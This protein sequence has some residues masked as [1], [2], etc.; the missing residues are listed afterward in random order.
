VAANTCKIT[1]Y[2][3]WFD[4]DYAGKVNLQ[5][6]PQQIA[7]LDSTF[8][9]NSLSVGLHSYHT[10]F[11][12]DGGQW[13]SVVTEVFHKLPIVAAN[14]RKITEYEYWFDNDYAAKVTTNVAPQ[15]IFTMNNGI[16]ASALPVGLHYFHTRFRDDGKQWSSVVSE[17]FHKLNVS[18]S[19]P[20]LIT[21]YR[22]WYDMDNSNMFSVSLP[23]PVNPYQLIRSI[24]TCNL[25][26]GDHRIHFQFKDLRQAWSSVI[27]D[28][29]NIPVPVIPVITP[30]GATTIC[31]GSTITL[32]ASTANSYLWNTEATSQSIIV[33]DSGSYS[34]S[35]QNEC[36]VQLTSE[37]IHVALHPV[38][39]P[40]VSGP[41]ASVLGETVVYSTEASMSNYNWE[42]SAGGMIIAGAGTN[43][44]TVNWIDG[45][46]QQVGVSYANDNGCSPVSPTILVVD[47]AVNRTLNLN[48]LLQGLYDGDGMM[49]KSQ[50]SNGDKYPGTIA[51]KVIIELHSAAADEY[52]TIVYSTGLVDLNNIGA[53]SVDIPAMHNGM[54]YV[55]VKHRN[56]IETVS[57]VPI[58][59]NGSVISYVF[60]TPSKAFG[61]NLLL[62][63]DGYP[64]IYAGDVNHDGMV[65]AED[66]NQIY[67]GSI[68]FSSGYLDTDINGDGI[69]DALD[70]IMTDNNASK[71]ISVMKP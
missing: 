7:I 8:N 20:N 45:G 32:T 33:S 66:I 71:F 50:D 55:T 58:Q 44:I 10:R 64:V 47:V 23:T 1:E 17:V 49:H 12:D 46:N 65:D 4:N 42:V 3:Y 9:T 11:R 34:V 5:T 18:P 37:A 43:S 56:S 19:I 29:F 15:Q 27:T 35:I 2:E 13:S 16:D 28:T 62:T 69:I 52:P 21:D 26:S 51:D 53:I 67:S 24:N 57:A 31:A 63:E 14:T 70:L 68:L 6:A 25:P 40:T 22:Y 60:D 30:S 38:P 36:G 61:S 54:Y 41:S 39:L 59:F 48:V